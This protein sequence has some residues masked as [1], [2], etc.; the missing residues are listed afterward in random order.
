MDVALVIKHLMKAC[1]GRQRECCISHGSWYG[2]GRLW[3]FLSPTECTA[4]P[5][6]STGHLNPPT[7]LLHPV[8]PFLLPAPLYMSLLILQAVFKS[9]K[10]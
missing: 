2:L 6:V 3:L 8:H 10:H 9:L 7:C 5:A 1:Q 4:Y